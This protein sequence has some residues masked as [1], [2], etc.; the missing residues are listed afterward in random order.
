MKIIKKYF[1]AMEECI[2]DFNISLESFQSTHS[3]NFLYTNAIAEY[4][5]LFLSLL[6]CDTEE[7]PKQ[8]TEELVDFTI[9]HDISYLFLYS[10]LV[11]V[12]RKLLGNLV[13]EEDFEHIKDINSFFKEHENRIA[14]LYL[15]KFLNQIKTKGEIRISHIESMSDKRFMI[16]YESHIKWIINLILYV[17][18]KECGDDYPQL[19]PKLCDFGKWMCGASNSYMLTTSHFQVIEKLHVN[20][21]D[22]AA[23]VIGYCQRKESRPATLI[24]L[25]EKIDYFSLEIGS[26]IAFLNEMEESTRDPLT[27]LL[28]RRLFDRIFLNNLEISK[29]TDREFSLI[30]CDLDH[31]KSI[32]DAY[33][34]GVGDMVLKHFS[35]YWKTNSVNQITSFA[36]VVKNL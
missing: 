18:A 21:H 25:M 9:E 24:H 11:T 29:A 4:K 28:T 8:K 34:H 30:M 32:N 27:K 31:F 12:I 6:L 14:V 36:L 26:E 20:L 22:L 33:G 7:G 5:E 15:E 19:N 23:N 1:I 17:Q 2:R 16:H 10:E 35:K 13:E 3:N